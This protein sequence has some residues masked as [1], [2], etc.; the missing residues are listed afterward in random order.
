MKNK[1]NT[2]VSDAALHASLHFETLQRHLLMKI[3]AVFKITVCKTYELHDKHFIYL[4]FIVILVNELLNF[5]FRESFM[6]YT[7][8]TMEVIR[9]IILFSHCNCKKIE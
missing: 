7:V 6:K 8:N 9:N 5:K 2:E 3:S 1:V 4:I